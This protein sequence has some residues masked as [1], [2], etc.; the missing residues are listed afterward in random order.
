M[1]AR[2]IPDFMIEKKDETPKE[3]G[4]YRGYWFNYAIYQ[5]GERSLNLNREKLAEKIKKWSLARGVNEFP[6][7][8][9]SDALI[10]ALPDLLESKTED[11][12]CPTS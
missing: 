12:Q 1:K 4:D 8:D 11:E 2:D 7:Y 6:M 10:A 5:Q 9:L 3:T